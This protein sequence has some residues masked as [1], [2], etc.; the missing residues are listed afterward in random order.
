[1]LQNITPLQI[2]HA[3]WRRN[4]HGGRVHNLFVPHDGQLKPHEVLDVGEEAWV[5]NNQ[6]LGPGGVPRDERVQHK[7]MHAALATQPPSHHKHLH[8]GLK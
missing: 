6:L 1:M 4:R 8:A 3:K 7:K 5:L 2:L